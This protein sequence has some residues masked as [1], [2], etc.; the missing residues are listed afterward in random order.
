MAD[1]IFD[2]EVKIIF[3]DQCSSCG[4]ERD[5]KEVAIRG[6]AKE[7]NSLCVKCVVKDM[8][9]ECEYKNPKSSKLCDRKCL[10][11]YKRSFSSNNKSK[12][13]L[14]ENAKTPRQIFLNTHTFY[15]FKCNNCNHEFIKSPHSINGKK[16]GVLIA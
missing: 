3:E 2:N 13:W 1:I 14:S 8:T 15:K 7:G 16:H 10:R 6:I 11:C 5:L 12:Y 9:E 4:K